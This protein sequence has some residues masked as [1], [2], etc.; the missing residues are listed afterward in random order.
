[1][2]NDVCEIN[3][4]RCICVSYTM[5]ND[6]KP[7]IVYKDGKQI[8]KYEMGSSGCHSLHYNIPSQMIITAGYHN[9]L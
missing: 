1:M 9:Q 2:I 6:K 4:L 5:M 3:H 7:F 8:V